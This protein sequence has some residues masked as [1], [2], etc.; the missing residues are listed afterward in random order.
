MTITIDPALL[1]ICVILF[2]AIWLVVGYIL[3]WNDGTETGFG[4]GWQ[5]SQQQVRKVIDQ[6]K[7]DR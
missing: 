7:A 6:I 1:V 2:A 4:A 5:A 3:G